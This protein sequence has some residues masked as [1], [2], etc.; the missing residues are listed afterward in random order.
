MTMR[1]DQ[2]QSGEHVK[3]MGGGWVVLS[4]EFLLWGCDPMAKDLR[5]PVDPPKPV[6]VSKAVKAKP[7]NWKRK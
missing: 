6:K 3:D 7:T 5:K 1:P 2:L 4:A